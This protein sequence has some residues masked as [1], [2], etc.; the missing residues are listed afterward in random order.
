MKVH[1]IPMRSSGVEVPRR[2]LNDRYTIKHSG[3]LVMMEVTDQGLRRPVKVARLVTP[4]P[5]ISPL[6]LM[7]PHLLW[8]N[9]DRFVLAGFESKRNASG[10]RVDYAQSW[11]CALIQ[12][13]APVER[14]SGALREKEPPR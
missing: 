2:M 5:N 9:A 3:D 8:I 11:L 6:E 1:V 10:E 13:V 12:P 4:H 14:P 7:D